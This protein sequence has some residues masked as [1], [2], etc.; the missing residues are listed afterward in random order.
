LTQIHAQDFKFAVI[1]FAEKLCVAQ[2]SFLGCASGEINRIPQVG[3]SI[4]DVVA[5]IPYFSIH[6]YN[7]GVFE[8]ESSEYADGIEGFERQILKFA[9]Q[10]I[11]QIES[12]NL[13]RVIGRI[14]P[15]NLGVLL[16]RFWQ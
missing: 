5:R 14:E 4:C 10:G 12:Q 15:D 2:F 7:W 3:D 6:G 9:R 8:V 11:V 1:G 16:I 13:R